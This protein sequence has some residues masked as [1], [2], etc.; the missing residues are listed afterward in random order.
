[1]IKGRKS[2]L[3]VDSGELYFGCLSNTQLFQSCFVESTSLQSIFITLAIYVRPSN[4]TLT[5]DFFSSWAKRAPLEFHLPRCDLYLP[6]SR[7]FKRFSR[8]SNEVVSKN[9]IFSILPKSMVNRPGHK[10]SYFN[11]TIII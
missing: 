6:Y 1:M 5:Q 10:K 3:T 2:L 11:T 7:N 8:R 4:S 9:I